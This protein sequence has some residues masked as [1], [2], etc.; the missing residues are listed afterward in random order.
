VFD[1][2]FTNDEMTEMQTSRKSFAT[3]KKHW[4]C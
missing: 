1:P 4:F 3:E 2:I